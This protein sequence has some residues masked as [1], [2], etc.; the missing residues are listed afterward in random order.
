M[1]LFYRDFDSGDRIRSGAMHLSAAAARLAMSIVLSIPQLPDAVWSE[2]KQLL[3]VD[4]IWGLCLVL[5][6]WLIATV[7]GG[8]VGLAVNGLLI[9]YGVV[10]M[11]DQLRDVASTIKQWVSAAY[12]AAN[13]SELSAAGKHFAELLSSGGL[14][15]LQLLVTHRI[16]R[17]VERRLRQAIP[18]PEW[19]RGRYEEAVTE[20][21]RSRTKKVAQEVSDAASALR[22]PGA[23]RAAEGIPTEAL[24]VTGLALGMATIGGV[25][26]LAS[27]AS[28]RRH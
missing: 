5:A 17:S 26:L 18:T 1:D 2:V 22:G 28:G 19:L 21:E 13:Q 7:I 16:F 15:I 8:L 10:E 4:T 25:A 24:V 9:A 6:G 20:R 3:T 12:Y 23:K 11:W 14:T 27:S